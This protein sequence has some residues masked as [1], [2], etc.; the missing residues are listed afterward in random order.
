[1]LRGALRVGGGAERS[2]IVQRIVG[3]LG[4]NINNN[5]DGD[6]GGG[7]GGGGGGLEGFASG[8]AS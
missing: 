2:V 4:G 3:A 1:M 7:D 5:V 8:R 6:G